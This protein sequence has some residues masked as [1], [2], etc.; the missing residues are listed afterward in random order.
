MMRL[1]D[2]LLYFFELILL[3]AICG[4]LTFWLISNVELIASFLDSVA[5]FNPFN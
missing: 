3:S 1:I 5:E 2:S 4:I